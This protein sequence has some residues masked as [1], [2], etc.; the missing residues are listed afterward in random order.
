[1]RSEE[2]AGTQIERPVYGRRV[3][4]SAPDMHKF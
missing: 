2:G 1:M 3:W 4:F